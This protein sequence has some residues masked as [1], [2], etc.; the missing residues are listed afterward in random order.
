MVKK[1][2]FS[3]IFVVLFISLAS[4]SFDMGEPSFSIDTDYSPIQ[5][6]IG[7]INISFTNE[8][9][10][11]LFSTNI[12]DSLELIELL[13]FAQIEGDYSCS[14]LGCE[15][16]YS[17]TSPQTTKNLEGNFEESEFLTGIM[18][19]GGIVTGIDKISFDANLIGNLG[20]SQTPQLIIDI[21]DNEYVDWQPYTSSGGFDVS[22]FS[23]C[24]SQEEA[25]PENVAGIGSADYC[26]S[27]ELPASP[28][29]MLGA[30]VANLEATGPVEMTFT[31]NGSST[32][33][34]CNVEAT[35]SGNITCVPSTTIPETRDYLVCLKTANAADNGD[36]GIRFEQ[37]DPCGSTGGF[38]YDFEIFAKPGTY[39][40]FS[41]VE[42]N[43][44]EIL[45]AGGPSNI[46]SEIM[47]Y[48]N[49]KYSLDCTNDCIVPI[50]INS[51]NKI[52][53]TTLSNLDVSYS[54]NGL[55]RSSNSFYD[56][57]SSPAKINSDFIQ[58]YLDDAL[59]N[60]HENTTA[61][62]YGNTS[63]VLD[64]GNEEVFSEIIDIQRFA[65]ISFLSPLLITLADPTTFT[66]GVN[67]FGSDIV[68]YFWNF[69]DGSNDTTT[70]NNTIHSYSDLGQYNIEISVIDGQ[71]RV[72][73]KSFEVNVTTPSGAVNETLFAREGD[74]DRINDQIVDF[75]QFQR[76]ILSSIIN[77][78][79]S[80]DI[81]NEVRLEFNAITNQTPIEDYISMKDKLDNLTLPRSL[82]IT[83]TGADLP[84][85]NG[86]GI[87]DLSILEEIEEFYNSEE[88]FKEL[89]NT[90]NA[91]NLEVKIG[92]DKV[93]ATYEEGNE[94]P[95]FSTFEFNITEVGD[96]W[97]NYHLVL[98]GFENLIFKED[99]SEIIEEDYTYI[100]LSSIDEVIFATTSDVG[101]IDLPA[102]ISPEIS[103]FST[104]GNEGPG[105]LERKEVKWALF[106]LAI[107][108]LILI[109]LFVY[110]ALQ[111]WYKNK[112]EKHLFKNRND[113]YNMIRFVNR[114]KKQGLTKSEIEAHLRRSKWS[115]EQVTY[116]L[117][118]Y[119]GK[120]TGM[121]ELPVDKILKKKEK[122]SKHPHNK[123][124]RFN[125]R[126]GK[127]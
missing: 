76:L 89:I 85:R 79:Q 8:P 87:I 97:G 101:F 91:A 115:S 32:Y 122:M 77:L 45:N 86:D 53:I 17:S 31:I 26:Q 27:I 103:D 46:E 20:V 105:W 50:K 13:G 123:F 35:S 96:I 80:Q 109:G 19:S 42:L 95:L 83:A 82:E 36:Y 54:S 62:V 52:E 59:L 65:E 71:S 118:K 58:V 24:F 4:A 72:S 113:L 12:G 21:M 94:V 49:N 111:K 44:S 126:L 9:I 18:F 67:T 15:I 28:S 61:I 120:R 60:V 63:F 3:F 30:T 68:S 112:Y 14:P 37:N 119:A 43:T 40:T 125:K 99:Y 121:Y 41:S 51:G 39:A 98:D 16:G 57:V 106:G 88:E 107:F 114:S 29:V 48:L 93:T 73:T 90:W 74:I 55:L 1:V 33:G 70:T 38:G 100:S 23:S 56:V 25:L 6:I 102:F 66:V 7:W 78:S 124:N 5:K 104:E 116:V 84:F 34:I 75:S 22:R 117:K 110:L 108:I 69:G 10:D 127:Y 2:I 64:L 92:F 81:I 11:S 47:N